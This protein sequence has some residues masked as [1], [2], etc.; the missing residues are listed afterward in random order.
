MKRYNFLHFVFLVIAVHNYYQGYHGNVRMNLRLLHILVER[1][2]SRSS[3]PSV[4]R[5]VSHKMTLYHMLLL[6]V[7]PTQKNKEK[8]Q[9]TA[10]EDQADVVATV[11]GNYGRWQLLMTFLLAMFSFPCT[12][13]IY[14][15]TF[16]VSA[17]QTMD[18]LFK[19]I[20]R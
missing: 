10:P 5:N 14:L 15:P 18:C 17:K 4:C 7:I 13:H 12:F 20:I 6:P 2:V 1:T 16:T 3:Y 8:S 19:V 11:I 9:A